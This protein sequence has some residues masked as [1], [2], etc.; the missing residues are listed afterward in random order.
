MNNKQSKQAQKCFGFLSVVFD[1]NKL[2]LELVSN[3]LNSVIFSITVQF[4]L[5]TNVFN[6]I[7]KLETKTLIVPFWGHLFC[8]IGQIKCLKI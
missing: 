5:I 2:T 7:F 4:G 3:Q 1:R 8:I 6:L